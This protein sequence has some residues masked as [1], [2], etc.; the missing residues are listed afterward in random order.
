MTEYALQGCFYLF[1]YCALP[2]L[3]LPAVKMSAQV[4]NYQGDSVMRR[5]LQGNHVLK[6]TI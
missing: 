4:L 6:I 1:L 2:V 3:P 5:G